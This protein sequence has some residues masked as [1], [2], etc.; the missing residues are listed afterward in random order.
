MTGTE[1]TLL[2]AILA[3][4][5]VAGLVANRLRQPLIV[6]VALTF[7][8]TIIIV[9]L[10]SD[11][12]EI[13]HLHGRIAVGFLIVRDLVA[14]LAMIGITASACP[15]AT[16]S[17]PAS[18][19]WRARGSA[20]WPG[21]RSPPVTCCPGCCTWSRS[22]ELLVLFAVAWAVSAASVSAWLGFSTEVGAF[23]AGVSLASGYP[24]RVS[25][26]AGL[27]V[28]QISGFSLILAALGFSLGHITS[29]TVSLIT[30]VGLITI[31]ASTYMILN[32]QA[33][34]RW[35]EP[36]LARFERRRPAPRHRRRRGAGAVLRRHDRRARHDRRPPR[37]RRLV[38]PSRDV[39]RCRCA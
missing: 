1:L 22:Q 9:K 23:L 32:W 8:S 28:A 33:L 20:C 10:L 11:Q 30:V 21:S 36:W 7:S 34:F 25:F 24:V 29:P 16:T 17:R 19:S 14:V 35:L 5:A 12:R 4:A 6:A 3:V 27:T 13:D 37:R 15:P 38:E 39:W 2:A 26:P 31:G 18:R